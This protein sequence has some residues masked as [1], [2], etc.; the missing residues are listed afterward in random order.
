[1]VTY[2]KTPGV[3]LVVHSIPYDLLNNQHV[4]SDLRWRFMKDME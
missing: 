2:T 3:P 1:M 4:Y